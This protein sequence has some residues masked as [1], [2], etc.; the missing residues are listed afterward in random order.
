MQSPVILSNLRHITHGDWKVLVL[1][2]DSRRIVD[3]VL[4]TD[5]ILNENI[6]ST[7]P[8]PSFPMHCKHVD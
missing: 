2:P 1:D 3:N 4:D 8:R 6:T 5:E 7:P